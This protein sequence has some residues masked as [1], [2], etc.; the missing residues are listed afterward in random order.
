MAED[1]SLHHEFEDPDG[2]TEKEK[3][4]MRWQAI[5]GFNAAPIPP[6]A[7]R[8]GI[9][10]ICHM[11]PK[12]RLCYVGEL[13]LSIELGAHIL[14][15]Q[16]AKKQ[17]K[18]AGL[19][20]WTNPGGPR[21][22]S[23][24]S[25]TWAA[26][27]RYSKQA[28]EAAKMAIEK[29]RSERRNNSHTAAM[30]MQVN[31]SR[32]AVI[33]P[34]QKTPNSSSITANAEFHHS[35]TNSHNSRRA[36]PITAV[37]LADITLDVPLK[38]VAQHITPSQADGGLG[39]AEDSEKLFVSQSA[40]QQGEPRR[41]LE[42]RKKEPP[43]PLVFFPQ[44]VE[45]LGKDD[46]KVTVAVLRLAFHEQQEASRLLATKGSAEALAYIEEHDPKGMAA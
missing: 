24:F 2:L 31:N 29:A 42:G 33:K 23:H 46:P 28:D 10:L 37:G 11:D 34:F 14:S 19:I 39:S 18:K 30:D 1:H 27:L 13:R 43:K 32:R 26:L 16:K 8:L 44:L 25:F 3:A 15:I 22:L 35:Q 45:V 5:Q 20:N 7:A 21:H 4:A 9:A 6:L 38:D 12:K 40:P 36:A 17:L 41:A